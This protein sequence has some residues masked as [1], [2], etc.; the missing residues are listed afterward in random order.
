MGF[1]PSRNSKIPV[2]AL[3]QTRFPIPL[4]FLYISASE[5]N[6]HQDGVVIITGLANHPRALV[7]EFAH[8]LSWNK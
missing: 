1:E 4:L 3:S 5:F 8:T 6:E 7:E 2:L